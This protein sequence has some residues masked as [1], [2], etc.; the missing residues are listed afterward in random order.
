MDMGQP[1]GEVV[2]DGYRFKA[3]ND[4]RSGRSERR[5]WVVC[6]FDNVYLE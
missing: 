6:H 1:A 3:G 5:R 2:G 4:R